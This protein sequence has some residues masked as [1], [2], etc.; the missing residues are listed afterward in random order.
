MSQN[1]FCIGFYRSLKQ[2]YVNSARL[3]LTVTAG[4]RVNYA[5]QTPKTPPKSKSRGGPCA[6]AR[7]DRLKCYQ[8]LR[9]HPG[10]GPASIQTCPLSRAP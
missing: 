8:R 6:I 9:G 5:A 3:W 2:T 1:L 10:A 4:H 7:H